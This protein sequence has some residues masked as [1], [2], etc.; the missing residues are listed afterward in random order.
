MPTTFVSQGE[1]DIFMFEAEPKETFWAEKVIMDY[2]RS[3]YNLQILH[4][5]S[6][7]KNIFL[8]YNIP[9]PSSAPVEWLF[10]LGLVLTPRR[11]ILAR[12]SRS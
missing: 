10:S 4:Q 8:K 12:G 5:S 3:A 6:N 9:T 11:N 7:I 2:L 1:M